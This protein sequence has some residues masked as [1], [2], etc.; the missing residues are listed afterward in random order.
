MVI[1]K[2]ARE[3]INELMMQSLHTSRKLHQTKTRVAAKLKLDRTLSNAE[4]IKYLKPH[5]KIKLLKILRRKTIRT[6]SGVSVIAIMTKP[7]SCP[8]LEPCIYCPGG[9]S[10]G[11]PQSYTGHEPAALR[12]TQNNYDPYSQVT[13]RIKQLKSIGHIVDK[14][15]LIIMG[16]TFPSTPMNYQTH[17]IQRALDAITL[18]PSKNFEEA[19][20]NAE[21]SSIR[22]VGITVETRPD[23]CKIPHI[24]SML[25]MGVTRVEIGVQ[26]PSDKI[27]KLAGRKHTVTDVTEATRIAK[28]SGLKVVYHLMPGMP[29]STPQKDLKAFNKIFSE[30]DFKPDMIKIYPCLVIEGTK[31]HDL[32]LQGKY[33]PYS[34]E[35]A[36]NLI[37]ELKNNIPSWIRIMRVQRDI[38]AGL[39]VAGV[40]KSNL[41][42]IV[43]KKM[44]ENNYLCKCIR[45][46]E[47]GHKL[48]RDNITPNLEDI[49]TITTTYNA[50]DGK[51]IFIS[52]E[53]LRNRI[54]IGYLRLRIPSSKAHR[55]EISSISSAI[56]RELHVY[57]PLVPVGIH[58]I[59]AW[60]HKGYG[61]ILLKEAERI[62]KNNYNV[63]K[64]LVISALGTKQ[65][66]RRFGYK[67]D[68]VYVSKNLT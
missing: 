8:Q 19:K 14:I 32:Y 6:I 56:V 17:F 42:Q 36:A 10:L 11:T 25:N 62:A 41:R 65:Y 46:R 53:D 54:L 5:E 63:K 55:P 64:I 12:G 66:Y 44:L 57:G 35:E 48:M 39:I 20:K 33:A 28:D 52:I 2:A 21:K 30:S 1:E 23:W 40:K 31:L 47:V 26:N 50:S 45:C 34:T 43:H 49:Q 18:L 7:H 13:A 22:N 67:R 9:T 60:Q 4:I 24:D 15:E 58:T 37:A 16:G 27:Y 51:E 61:S 3:I 68:G 38:P 59:K 29:G